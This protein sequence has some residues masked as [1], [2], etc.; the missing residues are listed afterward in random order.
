[1]SGPFGTMA[2]FSATPMGHYQGTG[3]SVRGNA[4]ARQE[5]VFAALQGG[6]LWPYG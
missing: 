4:E 2:W 6:G 1:M 5:S 3:E